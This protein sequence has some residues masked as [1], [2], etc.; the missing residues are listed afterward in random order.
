MKLS[1]AIEK[2]IEWRSYRSEKNTLKGYSYDL[3]KF[4]LF[5]RDCEVEAI[6]LD[7]ILGYFS[8][9]RNLGWTE[10]AFVGEASALR[11]FFD[12][13][14]R[15]GYRVVDPQL[16]P[17]PKVIMNIP[18]SATEEQYQKILSV[19]PRD[20]TD[21]RHVRNLSIVNM[22]WDTGARIGEIK[23]LD[24]ATLDLNRMRAV[25]KTE[26]SRGTR[27]LRE[28]FWTKETN[29]NIMQWIERKKKLARQMKYADPEALFINIA[30][31]SGARLS[32]RAI[33]DAFASYSRKAGI[34]PYLNPHSF[35]HH[36]GHDIIKKGGSNA[37]V[38]NILGHAKIESTMI[39]TM[40]ADRELE[41]RYRKFKGM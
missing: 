11:T 20:G 28:I 35:R 17:M 15:Q 6:C 37:D 22:L 3:R 23:A 4:C 32:P 33:T 14:L 24:I 40:M 25:I 41:A 8:M 21:P 9:L 18:R 13:Y 26:K 19:I 5:V 2:F 36:M 27:P 29:K 16:I 12:F 34:N 30:S 39:Y 31:N 1:E 10:K 38:M 7:E